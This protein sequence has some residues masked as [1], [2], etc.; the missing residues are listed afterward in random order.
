MKRTELPNGWHMVDDRDSIEDLESEAPVSFLFPGM[1]S[2]S[3]PA[4]VE[5]V[6]RVADDVC[7]RIEVLARE[8]DCLGPHSGDDE[9]PRAA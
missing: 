1:M 6:L 7:R 8:L 4:D 9:G 5:D 3:Q 2:D